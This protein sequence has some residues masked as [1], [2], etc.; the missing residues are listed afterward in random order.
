M[1]LSKYENQSL[2]FEIVSFKTIELKLEFYQFI[3]NLM[4]ILIH[5]E[6]TSLKN[7]LLFQIQK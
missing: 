5:L 3:R 4:S 2:L 7:W 1:K 6:L